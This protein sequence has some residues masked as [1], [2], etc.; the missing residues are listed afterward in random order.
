MKEVIET[1][2]NVLFTYGPFAIIV[3]LLLVAE[4]KLRRAK[5]EAPAE[6]RRKHIVPYFLNWAAIFGLVIYSVY[7]WDRRNVGQGQTIKGTIGRLAGHETIWTDEN[8]SDSQLYL[9]KEAKGERDNLYFEYVWRLEAAKRFTGD[10]EVK[11]VV[12]RS[13]CSVGE[14]PFEYTLRVKPEFYNAHVGISYNREQNKMTVTSG[15]V[16][17]EIAGRELPLISERQETSRSFFTTVAHAQGPFNGEQIAKGLEA[18]DPN[19]RRNTRA[20]LARGGAAALRWIEDVLANPGSSYR[21]RLGVIVALNNMPGLRVN[22]L[23]MTT[24]DAIIKAADDPDD[25]LRNEARGLIKRHQLI[26]L[27]VYEHYHYDGESH[28][29]LPGK[30]LARGY[31]SLPLLQMSWCSGFSSVT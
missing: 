25:V 16:K 8:E 23:R 20:E 30:H 3:L 7:E 15:N 18:P 11:F 26:P 27:T 10:A 12:D 4:P 28:D 13:T 9:R 5:N 29:F 31:L 19:V 22:T 21:L 24:V 14:Q 6:E 2:S 17:E 1:L